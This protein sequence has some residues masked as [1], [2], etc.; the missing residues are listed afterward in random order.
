MSHDPY[1]DFAGRYDL[2][3]GEFGQ[4]DAEE[5]GFFRRV[6]ARYQ[7][8]SVL[9]CACGTGRHLPLFHALGLTVTGSD[10]S[11]SML[12]QARQNLSGLGLDLPLHQVDYRRLAQHFD[13]PFGAVVCLSS[14][15]LHMPDDDQVLQAFQSMRHV[16]RPGGILIL[17]QGTT[18]RQWTE[19]PRFI[20][21]ADTPGFTRLFVIDYQEQGAHYHILDV[22]RTGEKPELKT[23]S[24][25]YPRILLADDQER[26]LRAAGFESVDL[27]G[28]FGFD[29]YDKEASRRLIAVAQK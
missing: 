18:D 3:D 24:M 6:F 9:D 7:V 4:H 27:Y 23:W 2:F 20:L 14:S 1:A 8:R 5:A 29:P 25:H 17:T 26:L 11:P 12:A 15:I 19:K 22:L 13:R 16:L 28:S 10:L 21:A